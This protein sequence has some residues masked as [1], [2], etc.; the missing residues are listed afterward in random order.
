M[1]EASQKPLPL[2]R[3]AVYVLIFAGCG[4]VVV[5]EVYH[6]L[7]C[8]SVMGTVRSVGSKSAGGPRSGSYFFADYE[9]LD[10]AGV[11][12]TGRANY[13]LATT[14]PGDQ[15]EVQYFRHAPGSSRPLPSP[16]RALSYGAIAL[17]AAVV[18]AAE[19][20]TRRRKP[21]ARDVTSSEPGEGGMDQRGRQGE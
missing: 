1:S 6:A 21:G 14:R 10:A 16:V 3:L 12:H 2:V 17:L 5:Y 7:G 19:I 18:F 11:R 20:L 4:A 9:Y 8:N 15:I 13:V